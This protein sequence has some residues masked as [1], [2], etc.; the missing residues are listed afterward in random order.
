M[1]GRRGGGEID[2]KLDA[3]LI[4][5]VTMNDQIHASVFS[6][7]VYLILVS[8]TRLDCGGEKY[9]SPLEIEPRFLNVRLL[10]K[11]LD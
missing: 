8:A 1:P 2:L 11:S 3:I 9:L 7:P 10:A 5:A 4:F 6:P